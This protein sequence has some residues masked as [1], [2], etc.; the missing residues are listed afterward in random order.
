MAQEE[1]DAARSEDGRAD[2]LA[3]GAREGVR[4]QADSRERR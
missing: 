1:P 3:R 2:P 4:L